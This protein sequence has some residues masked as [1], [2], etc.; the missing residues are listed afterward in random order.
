MHCYWFSNV[1]VLVRFNVLGPL[2]HDMDRST[3]DIISISYD[4]S[5]PCP[6]LLSNWYNLVSYHIYICRFWRRASTW[7]WSSMTCAM[8]RLDILIYIL[9]SMLCAVH[10]V[11]TCLLANIPWTIQ[12][13]SFWK[14][15]Y[16]FWNPSESHSWTTGRKLKYKYIQTCM[17]V[18]IMFGSTNPIR[19]WRKLSYVPTAI[20]I[21]DARSEAVEP[22]L[23]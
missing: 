20:I 10:I 13:K 8:L 6:F 22:R 1:L 3:L 19:F 11:H 9:V 15:K 16:S 18:C 21:S 12:N 7:T 5:T 14:W 17:Y 23:R 4:R 2:P